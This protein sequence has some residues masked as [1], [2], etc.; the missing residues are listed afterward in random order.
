MHFSQGAVEIS[1]VIWDDKKNS[2]CVKFSNQYVKMEGS[3]FFQVPGKYK[4]RSV[5]GGHI[6][7]KGSHWMEIKREKRFHR[8][9]ILNFTIGTNDE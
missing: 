7:R 2:L 6:N 3:I 8:E 5:I 4:M 1:D 9:M